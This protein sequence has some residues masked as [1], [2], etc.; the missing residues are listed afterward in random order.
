MGRSWEAF[1]HGAQRRIFGSKMEELKW[2]KRK[3][4]TE[5]CHNLHTLTK[6]FYNYQIHLVRNT[7]TCCKHVNEKNI[8]YSSNNIQERVLLENIDID[9][10]ITLRWTLKCRTKALNRFFWFWI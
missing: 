6:Y 2:G 9:G 8:K 1:K 5:D 4:K 3:L 10:S 7:V